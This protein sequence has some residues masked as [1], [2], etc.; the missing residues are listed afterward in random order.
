MS[1]KTQY[2]YFFGNGKADGTAQMRDILG[3]K[4]LTSPK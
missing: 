1:D 4:A 3:A 2:V